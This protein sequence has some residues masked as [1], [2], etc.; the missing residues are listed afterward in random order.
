MDINTHIISADEILP[1]LWLGNE[2][3][4]QSAQFMRDKNIRVIVNASQNIPSKFIGQ[5]YYIRVPVDDPGIYGIREGERNIDV[6]IMKKSLPLVLGYIDRA[7][8]WNM[9]ILV[10]CHAGAQRSATIVAMYLWKC[11]HAHT[12]NDAIQQVIKKRSIAFFGGDSVN[13][14][15]VFI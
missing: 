8:K 15:Q 14:R 5:I 4:S 12:A 7:R 2:A 3:T 1:G 10:H 13:F 6:K 11:G 9:N